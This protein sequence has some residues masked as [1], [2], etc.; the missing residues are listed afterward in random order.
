VEIGVHDV[1][2][3]EERVGTLTPVPGGGCS[4]AYR[5]ELA[6]RREAGALPLSAAL[7]LRAEPFGPEQSSAYLAGLLPEGRAR[8]RLA[9]LVG[10]DPAD[11]HR[12]IGAAGEDCVGAIV[13][14]PRDRETAGAGRVSNDAVLLG[15]EE[16]ERLVVGSPGEPGLAVRHS[17]PGARHKLALARDDGGGWRLPSATL[18][19]THVVK[20]GAGD[21]PGLLRN[22]LFCIELGRRVGI[23]VAEAG[24]EVVGG[25]ECL[26]S[27][28]FD[29]DGPA[30]VHKED[31]CQALGLPPPGE[32]RPG[33]EAPSPGLGEVSELLR[34]SAGEEDVARL[35]AVALFAYVI[36]NGDAHGAGFGLLH[37]SGGTRLAPLLDL[38]ST[39]V[40]D[41]PIHVGMVI[42]EDFDQ[43]V[44][45][46][47]LG[48][49]C[50]EC[51]FDFDRMRGIAGNLAA[52]VRD[53]LG[54]LA[55][56]ARAEGWHAPVI[57]DIVGLA[58]ERATGLG[59]EVAG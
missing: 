52:R 34:A 58:A 3:G 51:G 7:P 37:D 15:E 23:P 38:R 20:P 26:V 9:R 21:L 27:R 57:D 10:A 48:C 11:E 44:H 56:R 46:L 8:Q 39:V 25:R 22:Q 4:F 19:S 53:A 33:S 45:L 47:E 6:D 40:Y 35:L 43:P 2:L 49:V 31:I 18:P 1:L 14:A 24:I 59:Y 32:S 54:P 28:R 41:L 55:E 29:R 17:L 13:F 5:P 42:A 16:L 12:L 36:G 50:E 30:R